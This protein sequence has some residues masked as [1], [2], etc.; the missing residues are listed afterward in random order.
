LP[1]S[2]PRWQ[3]LEHRFTSRFALKNV[4]RKWFRLHFINGP[5]G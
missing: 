3:P 2:H 5:K 1:T 4:R